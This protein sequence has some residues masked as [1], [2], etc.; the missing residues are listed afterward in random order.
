MA[1]KPETT[2]WNGASTFVRVKPLDM[3]KETSGYFPVMLVEMTVE[4]ETIVQDGISI[5][6]RDT[7][8]YLRKDAGKFQRQNWVS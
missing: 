3:F 8:G 1:V 6:Q 2:V 7:T 5:R 4:P